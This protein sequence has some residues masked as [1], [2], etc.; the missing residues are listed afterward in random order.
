MYSYQSGIDRIFLTAEQTAQLKNTLMIKYKKVGGKTEVVPIYSAL[1]STG[2]LSVKYRHNKGIEVR[3]YGIVN[4][5]DLLKDPN[6]SQRRTMVWTDALGPL[7][8]TSAERSNIRRK[9]MGSE[10]KIFA[11]LRMCMLTVKGEFNLY[12]SFL[13]NIIIRFAEES[14]MGTPRSGLS[15][16]S[17][18]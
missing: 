6:S 7:Y 18:H 8:I 15:C 2:L 10:E 12:V 3:V 14:P 5:I 13:I 11:P 1:P 9:L 4:F 16:R 17:S